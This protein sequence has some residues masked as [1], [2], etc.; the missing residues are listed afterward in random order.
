MH[1]INTYLHFFFDRNKQDSDDYE[2]EKTSRFSR[3]INI[4]PEIESI[5]KLHTV[6]LSQVKVTDSALKM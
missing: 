4:L 6:I 5:I 3:N 1:D 2:Y